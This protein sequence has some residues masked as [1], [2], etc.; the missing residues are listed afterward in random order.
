VLVVASRSANG[1]EPS[2]G[3]ED[4]ILTKSWLGV[5]KEAV[6]AAAGGAPARKRSL[7][8]RYGVWLLLSIIGLVGKQAYDGAVKSA[9][10]AAGPSAAAGSAA[11]KKKTG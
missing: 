4:A 3:S 1:V 5:R 11:G 6:A 10:P 7:F 8:R 2:A 9:K